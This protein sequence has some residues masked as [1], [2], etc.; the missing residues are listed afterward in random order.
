MLFIYE[1]VFWTYGPSKRYIAHV[2]ASYIELVKTVLENQLGRNIS[3][4]VCE[5]VG[6]ID[7]ASA[8]RMKPS[9]FSAIEAPGNPGA[10]PNA[11]VLMLYPIE[12]SAERVDVVTESG[13]RFNEWLSAF[14]HPA[15]DPLPQPIPP[16]RLELYQ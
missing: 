3:R 2:A 16:R 13:N 8:L 4:D 14:N 10:G 1:V 12:A 5:V 11:A 7:Q 15:P 6:I 9:N